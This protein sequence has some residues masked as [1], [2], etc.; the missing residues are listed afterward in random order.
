MKGT[1]STVDFISFTTIS[2]PSHTI[3]I[4]APIGRKLIEYE[5]KISMKVTR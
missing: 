4:T 2:V 5:R 1:T 3:A